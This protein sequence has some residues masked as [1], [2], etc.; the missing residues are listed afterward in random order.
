M[1]IYVFKLV[2]SVLVC[3]THLVVN[4]PVHTSIDVWCVIHTLL[5]VLLYIRVLMFFNVYAMTIFGVCDEY[6]TMWVASKDSLLN[7]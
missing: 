5:S 6:I 2:Y 1:V 4:T 3:D 7:L